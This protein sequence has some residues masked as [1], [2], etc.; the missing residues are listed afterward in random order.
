MMTMTKGKKLL[1]LLGLLIGISWGVYECK[2]YF[3]YYSDL[4]TRPWAYSRDTNAK[5]LVGKW[6]G[7]FEDPNGVS[8]TLEVEIFEPVSEEERQKKA[9]KKSRRRGGREN[10]RAFDGTATVKSRL[11]QEEYEIYGAVE[12]EDFHK[13]SFNFRPQDEAKRIL[14]NFTLL[15]ANSG[16]WETDNLLLTLSF[17][18]QNADGSSSSS[19]EGIVRNGKIEWQESKDDKKI[20][21]SL[22]RMK[23]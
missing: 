5:L 10:K 9:N 7:A 22:K 20:L 18:R 8:K 14:P 15:E 11:G 19:S 23:P 21:A 3:S 6:Q 1:L 13:L 2:Y 4:Q 16:N 12:K 17:S